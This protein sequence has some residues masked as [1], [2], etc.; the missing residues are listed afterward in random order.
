MKMFAAPIGPLVAVIA[1][2]ATTVAKARQLEGEESGEH[3]C[4]EQRASGQ[5]EKFGAHGCHAL[6]EGTEK[7]PSPG[8][9]DRGDGSPARGMGR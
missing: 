7:L 3:D 5:A 6:S 1:T 4:P 8:G 9:L 2:R